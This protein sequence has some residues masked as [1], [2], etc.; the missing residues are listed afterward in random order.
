M[1]HG[2]YIDVGAH[3][4]R[5]KSVSRGFY[6]RGWRG[7]HFEPN[8]AYAEKIRRDRPDEVVHEVALSN[9]EGTVRFVVTNAS[10]MSTGALEL[11]DAYRPLRWLMARMSGAGGCDDV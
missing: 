9:R 5:C 8:P 7:V 6:E 3:D 4:P 1:Q 11:V 2:C 10:G